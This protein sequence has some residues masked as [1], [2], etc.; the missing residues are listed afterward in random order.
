MT[1]VRWLA[2]DAKLSW[3]RSTFAVSMCIPAH[4]PC[5]TLGPHH[6]HHRAPSPSHQ[7]P[8]QHCAPITPTQHWV[9]LTSTPMPIAA[10]GPIT[11][12]MP[13]RPQHHTDGISSTQLGLITTP[14]FTQLSPLLLYWNQQPHQCLDIVTH[15]SPSPKHHWSP[16]CFHISPIDPEVY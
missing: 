5:R 1:D 14:P 11:T 9:P 2:Q 15:W 13:I 7:C 6:P 12:P 3:K 10:L 4:R 8:S 16:Q